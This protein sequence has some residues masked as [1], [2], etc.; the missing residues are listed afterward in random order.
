MV[1]AG[2]KLRAAQGHRARRSAEWIGFLREKGYGEDAGSGEAVTVSAP[3]AVP[4]VEVPAAGGAA[5]VE[6]AGGESSDGFEARLVRNLERL[7]DACADQAAQAMVGGKTALA[8][9]VIKTGREATIALETARRLARDAAMA[10]REL[11]SAREIEEM[12]D[13]VR[14]AAELVQHIDRDLA[15]A[16]NPGEPHVA[17]A[18]LRNWRDGRWNQAIEA[19]EA[20]VGG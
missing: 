7:A 5:D 3:P 13:A 16:C 10:A 18:A 14:R 15:D 12:L 20:A 9:Q 8:Q 1:S 2:L 4:A 6:Q 17:A 19:I 11:V